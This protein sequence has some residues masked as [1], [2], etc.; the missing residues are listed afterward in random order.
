M[1]Y[2]CGLDLSSFRVNK[3]FLRS[4]VVRSFQVAGSQDV[5]TFT[6]DDLDGENLW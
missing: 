3:L 6:S 1:I 4:V 5:L 2:K